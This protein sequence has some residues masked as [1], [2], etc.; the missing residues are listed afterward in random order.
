MDTK[1]RKFSRSR[2]IKALLAL[3]VL[4]AA[5]AIGV[6]TGYMPASGYLQHN[7]YTHHNY[8]MDTLLSVRFTESET[9]ARMINDAAYKAIDL[10]GEK[11]VVPEDH[12]LYIKIV[13]KSNY[14]HVWRT[15]VTPYM[16]YKIDYTG[17]SVVDGVL[18]ECFRLF[19][20]SGDVK[21]GTTIYIGLTE[22]SFFSAKENWEVSRRNMLIIVFSSLA[23]LVISIAAAIALCHVSAEAP[24]GTPKWNMFFAAPYEVS[25]AALI[26]AVFFACMGVASST[27]ISN[28]WGIGF[29]LS[30]E[31][32]FLMVWWG[33]AAAGIA[34]LAL[35]LFMSITFRGKN[36]KAAKGCLIY[37]ILRGLWKGLCR[38]C[39]FFKELFTGELFS[40]GRVSRL[41]L[42][43]D[44]IFLGTSVVLLISFFVFFGDNNGVGIFSCALLWLAAL[45]LFIFGRYRL[46]S[47]E[48]K[49]EQQIH[50][51]SRGNYGY[52]PQLS[53]NSPYIRS[54]DIL[55]S[56]S[57]RYK[58]G[59]EESVKAERMKIELVTNVSH[60][61]KTPLTSIISYVDLLSKE[62]LSPQA[63]EYVEI[64]QKK[65]ERLKNIVADVFE[66][67][68]TTSGEISVER[69]RLDLT[70]LSNQTLAEMEDK[71]TAAGFIVKASLCEP[72]VEVIS[73]GK[74][75]YRVIQNLMDNALKYSLKGTRIFYT[76]E[77]T[78]AG[79]AI[80]TIKNIAGYDMDFTKEEILERFTRGDKSRTTEGSGLGLSIAQGF[81][82]ACGGQ[83]DIDIDGDMFKVIIKFHIA[84]PDPEER[85]KAEEKQPVTVAADE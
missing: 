56:I 12:D 23:L 7:G 45:G 51:L 72:P 84:A 53:K 79:E 44:S 40:S 37:V 41:L 58:Q 27:D 80:I 83:F 31:R 19:D 70:R 66:L 43:I 18:P 11:T 76:L 63:E 30:F 29:K 24:D 55:S 50:E 8:A 9:F 33:L 82:I 85:E 38:L 46:I 25:L 59:I 75:L 16:T 26:L 34:A 13:N 52:R 73:D 49:L 60:D 61:L 47:D 67:A 4:G 10:A 5:A 22:E 17:L 35:Y 2:G 68:K 65:S 69:E 48:A 42:I 81:T 1:W 77:K 57:G 15:Q 39:R 3:I 14:S 78:P 28:Y 32:I 54:S 64:L 20:Y 6:I 36:H 21:E 62:E 71:I 74:R